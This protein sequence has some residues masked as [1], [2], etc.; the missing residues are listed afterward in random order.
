[1]NIELDAYLQKDADG[2]DGSVRIS[3]NDIDDIYQLASL[4]QD[5]AVALGF[6][7]VKAVGFEKDDG[8]IVWS[9]F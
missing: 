6:T 9:D 7:Y 3:R 1:M 5:F 2:C 8:N 4:F